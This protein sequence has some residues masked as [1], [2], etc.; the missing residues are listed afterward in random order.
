MVRLIA[1]KVVSSESSTN[2][3]Q[4]HDGTIDRA[5]QILVQHKFIQFQFH[6]G[7]IDSNQQNHLCGLP[8]NFNST[9]V[10]LIVYKTKGTQLMAIFQ[11]HDGTIDRNGQ[12]IV[13][14][15]TFIISIP[16]WYD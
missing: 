12:D 1:V 5:T 7:T 6:D 9:M 11:F 14:I 10:R 13:A 8:S 15:K 2:V 16:R 3:F 4:F